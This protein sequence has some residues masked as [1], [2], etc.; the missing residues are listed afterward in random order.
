[1]ACHSLL[2]FP[3]FAFGQ[4]QTETRCVA[5]YVDTD[6]NSAHSVNAKGC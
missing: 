6:S 2:A 4:A 5:I 1:M 3:S